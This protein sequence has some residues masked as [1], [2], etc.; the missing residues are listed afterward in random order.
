MTLLEEV[1]HLQRLPK[2][3]QARAIRQAAGISQ[4]RLAAELGV[5]RV[6]L[7]RWEAGERMPRGASRLAYADLLRDLQHVV[8]ADEVPVGA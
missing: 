3:A 5:H 7:L 2:P 8:L 1:R 4:G 6:T